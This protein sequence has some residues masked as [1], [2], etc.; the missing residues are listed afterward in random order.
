M[1]KT[2]IHADMDAFYAAV[3]I[4]DN[5]DLAGKPLI[6][7]ALPH[8]RGVVS[9][10]SYEARKFGIRSGMSIK[11]AYRRCPQGIY[12]HPNMQKNKAASAKLH[13][14]WCSYTD[15]VEYVSLDEGYLDVTGSAHMFGGARR[16]ALAIKERT[17]KE[18]G[19]TCSVGIGYSMTSAKL[20]SEEKKPDGLFEIP[21]PEFF[22]NLII[23][24]NVKVLYGIG[25]KTAEKL[26][27][28]N[29]RTV[30]DIRHNRQKVIELLGRH[31]KQIVELA[32]G[33]DNRSVTPYYEAEAKSIGKEHTF[34]QDIT[35]FS[36]LKDFL[37]LIA[38]DLSIKIRL[39][40][41]YCR[42]ITLKVTYWNMKSITRSKSGEATNQANEIYKIAASLLDTVEKNPV[43]LV[44]ISLANLSETTLRQLTLDDIS[45][46]QTIKHKEDLEDKLL[47]LQCKYGANII[48][49]GIEL[50]AEK[51][52]RKTNN[53]NQA[54]EGMDTD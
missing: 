11:D 27:K 6:I 54:A 30:R 28:V 5:P 49:T 29:I 48:K 16:I 1:S 33:I 10:C 43:R 35:D 18:T 15:I 8:E 37:I 53:N 2:I 3:E 22:I 51:H 50:E 13:E 7:G 46:M 9:T 23:D 34:Q 14:I 26:Q 45:N 12:M 47:A 19:L 52:L 24:R 25:S 31:G 21:N 17:R 36:Y 44:G 41:L 4:R 39:D 20:A 38:R 32:D 42:T 40:G